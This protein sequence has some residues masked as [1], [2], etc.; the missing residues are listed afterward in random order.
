[1]IM[2]HFLRRDAFVCVAGAIVLSSYFAV[3]APLQANPATGGV[4]SHHVGRFPLY[5]PSLVDALLQLGKHADQ[6]LG[7]E[8]IDLKEL[9]KPVQVDVPEGTLD[10][11]I[12]AILGGRIGYSW[13]TRDGVVVITHAGISHGAANLLNRILPNFSIARCSPQEASLQLYMGLLRLL[14]PGIQGIA[15]DYNPG[16]GA[17]TVGPLRLI[18]PTVREVLNRIASE[19]GHVAWVIQVTPQEMGRLRTSG[20][21]SLVEYNDASA[22]GHV[23]KRLQGAIQPFGN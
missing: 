22:M 12:R 8:Y 23:G 10:N 2:V 16:I 3:Q 4:L 1:M 17:K 11:S 15:G 20:L 19:D 5:A 18:H 7:I 21:W 9:R 6:P 14:Q 13:Y